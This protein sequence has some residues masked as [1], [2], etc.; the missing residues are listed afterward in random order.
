M[1]KHFRC[2]DCFKGKEVKENIIMIQCGRCGSYMKDMEV[3][4]GDKK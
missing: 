4:D 1:K 3:K 2:P